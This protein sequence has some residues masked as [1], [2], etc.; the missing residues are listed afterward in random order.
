ML[1]LTKHSR[2]GMQTYIE[3]KSWRG[4]TP[5]VKCGQV[6]I[7]RPHDG[8]SRV[9]VRGPE[10]FTDFEHDTV[11]VLSFDLIDVRFMGFWGGTLMVNG[12]FRPQT[13]TD[14]RFPTKEWLDGLNKTTRCKD[15]KPMHQI[16]SEGHYCPKDNPEEFARVRDFEVEIRGTLGYGE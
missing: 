5:W 8:V 13:P 4:S 12:Y 6:E 10:G 11:K 15:C 9:N 14:F 2:P 7:M 1:D 3:L 16:V